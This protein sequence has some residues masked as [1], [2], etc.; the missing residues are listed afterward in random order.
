MWIRPQY[1]LEPKSLQGEMQK[2]LEYKCAYY[3][4]EFCYEWSYFN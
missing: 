1:R 3:K 2:I 4:H